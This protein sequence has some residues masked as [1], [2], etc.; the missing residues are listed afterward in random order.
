MKQYVVSFQK[1]IAISREIIKTER[2]SMIADESTTLGE[3][4]LWFRKHDNGL[5]WD[6]TSVEVTQAETIG[7]LDKF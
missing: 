7:D 6:K 4:E 3:I 2:P 1:F 5:T